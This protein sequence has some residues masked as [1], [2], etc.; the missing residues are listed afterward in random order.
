[1]GKPKPKPNNIWY[2]QFTGGTAC[3]TPPPTPPPPLSRLGHSGPVQP[4]LQ[5]Q[6]PGALRQEPCLEQPVAQT[7]V[8]HESPTHCCVSLHTH[9]CVERGSGGV[10]PSGDVVPRPCLLSTP[11]A[12]MPCA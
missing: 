12:C 3:A 6:A 4:S 11:C 7:A 2:V 5:L 10:K 9:R 1:M 8:L